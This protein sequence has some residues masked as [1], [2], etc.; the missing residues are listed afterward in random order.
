MPILNIV[1][2]STNF[3]HA[4]SFGAA[5]SQFVADRSPIWSFVST[6]QWDDGLGLWVTQRW[7][8]LL[9]WLTQPRMFAFS[10]PQDGKHAEHSDAIANEQLK[11]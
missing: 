4:G 1:L 11:M 5:F 6:H 10:P 8:D 3:T 9:D 7:T 2:A